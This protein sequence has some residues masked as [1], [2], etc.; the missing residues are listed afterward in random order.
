MLAPH[1]DKDRRDRLTTVGRSRRFCLLLPI[2][3]QQ[4]LQT[5]DIFFDA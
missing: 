4:T 1:P 3:T 5:C 2:T